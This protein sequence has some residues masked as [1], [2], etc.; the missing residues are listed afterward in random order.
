LDNALIRRDFSFN[1]IET[2]DFQGELSNVQAI[3]NAAS[4]YVNGF[5][6]GITVNFSPSLLLNSQL[7]ITEGKEQLD[8]GTT[9]PLRHVAP[10][11]GNTHLVWKRD[12]LKLDLFGEYNG[13]FDHEDLAPSEQGKA[14]LYAIDQNGN[15]YSP[16]WYTIN[17]TGQYE[18]SYNWLVTVSLENITDQRYRTY[19]SGIAAPGRNLIL[20]LKYSL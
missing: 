4:A 3:Q 13:Q 16:S 1:G 9:A 14:Y 15:P 18:I 20:A 6:G 11:F 7:T 12:K 2:I 5:E 10:I 8:N 17:F 19:S